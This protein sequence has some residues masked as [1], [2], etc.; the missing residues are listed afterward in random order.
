MKI[1]KL[2]KIFMLL[3]TTFV[4]IGQQVVYAAASDD[5]QKLRNQG[6]YY[7]DKQ[8]DCSTLDANSD[9]ISTNNGD[10]TSASLQDLAKQM[11]DNKKITYWTN[12]GINT[13]DVVVALS[14]GKKAY[15]TAPN[16]SNKEVDL[17]PN[18]LLFILDASKEGK[19]MV[20][21]LTDKTHT[22]GSNHY[23]GLAVDIDNG[24]GNTTVPLATLIN[25]AKTYGGTKNSETSHYHFDFT[26]RTVKTTVT[27][28][29]TPTKD[30]STLPNSL[31]GVRGTGLTQAE[32]D[33]AKSKAK[34]GLSIQEGTYTGTAY[35]PPWEGIQGTGI[36]STGIKL[37]KPKY[38]VASDP[39][40]RLPYGSFVYITPNPFNW[41][42]PF[43]V[44]DTGGAFHGSEA[45]VDFY[46]WN[47]R[48]HQNA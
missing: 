11:L 36:T 38:V 17:N 13:R 43:L 16:A 33:S 24:A 3:I 7:Y 47:G 6:I 18:I 37:D 34:R 4:I 41:D 48:N 12:N 32:I 29:D 35:G 8:S 39:D 42:G 9:N 40:K 15:T 28:Q 22:D 44:A 19:I 31:G 20:N 23:Q 25:I 46:D 5:I 27:Q 1:L 2:S 14:E 45:K 10:T 21:A 26:D 30:E